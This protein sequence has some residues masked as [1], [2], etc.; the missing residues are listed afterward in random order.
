MCDQRDAMR[1]V[2]TAADRLSAVCRA[3]SSDT[4]N[5]LADHFQSTVAEPVPER[6]ARL[7]DGLADDR[8]RH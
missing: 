1:E 6:L 2:R 5:A 7:L 4:V 8:T 3:R